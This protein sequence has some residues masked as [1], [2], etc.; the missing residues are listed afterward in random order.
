[1]TDAAPLRLWRETIR[2]EWIDYNGH[3]NVAYYTLVFDRAVDALFEHV[4]LGRA[5][6]EAGKGS[7]FAVEQHI[8][9]NR[10]VV[11]GDEVRI[12]T[13]LAGFDEKR[14]HH[15]HEMFH[16]ADGYLAA[17]TEFLSLHVDLA[18]RR[19]APF[20]DAITDRLAPL[21]A[22]HAALPPPDALGRVIRVPALKR[23]RKSD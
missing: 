23:D 18:T 10:E 21:L 5:Y 1:M 9:Y 4:G 17:T 7:T 12:E 6:R 3:M 11:E 16:A 19:V 2:P 20:P 22:A 14:I 8:T 15:Y 13:R